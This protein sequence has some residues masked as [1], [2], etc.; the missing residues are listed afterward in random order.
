MNADNTDPS[1]REELLFMLQHGGARTEE[2]ARR[3]VDLAIAEA[4]SDAVTAIEDPEQRRAASGRDA[5][6]WESARDVLNR[7]TR[8][9]ASAL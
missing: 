8:K 2:I 3:V 9:T 4:L 5:H 6:G 1:R 7:L